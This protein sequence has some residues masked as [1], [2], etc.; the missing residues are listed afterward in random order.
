MWLFD[1]S[2]G[3]TQLVLF[4]RPNSTVAIDLNIDGS[5]LQEKPSFKIL[6]LSFSTKLDWGSNIISIASKKL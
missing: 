5:V 2:T 1:F 3:K 6:G 4:D